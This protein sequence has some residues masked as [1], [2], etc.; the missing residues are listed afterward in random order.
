MFSQE[1]KRNC[2]KQK[3]LKVVQYCKHH[4]IQKNTHLLKQLFDILYYNYFPTLSGCILFNHVFILTMILLYICR[5]NVN[6]GNSTS[7]LVWLIKICFEMSLLNKLVFEALSEIYFVFL[8]SQNNLI[9]LLIFCFPCYFFYH[10]N[11]LQRIS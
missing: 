1:D 3:I 7:F 10:M 6:K 4:K 5:D 11:F 2:N 8:L 9:S